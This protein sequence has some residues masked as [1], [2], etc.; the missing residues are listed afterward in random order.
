[1]KRDLKDRQTLFGLMDSKTLK[2]SSKGS[3]KYFL[4][5]NSKI[6][7]LIKLCKMYCNLSKT[8][9]NFI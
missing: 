3:V 8:F 7:L 1:M 5:T 9:Q 4:N 6:N 2:T